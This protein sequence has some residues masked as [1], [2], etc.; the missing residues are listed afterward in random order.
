MRTYLETRDSEFLRWDSTQTRD[1]ESPP[2]L[3]LNE[4][5]TQAKMNPSSDQVN[6]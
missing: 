3:D 6:V 4:E 5:D 2:N 1:S